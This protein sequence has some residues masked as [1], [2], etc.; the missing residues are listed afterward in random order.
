MFIIILSTTGIE[1]RTLNIKVNH[2]DLG[3]TISSF[4]F[5]RTSKNLKG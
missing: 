4:G 5:E 3:G 1:K 2:P